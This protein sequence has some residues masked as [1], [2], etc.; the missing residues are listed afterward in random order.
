MLEELEGKGLIIHHWDTDGI[1]STHILLWHLKD[2][3]IDNKT[4]ELGNYYLTE[5]EIKNYSKYDF[6]YCSLSPIR[7]SSCRDNTYHSWRPKWWA[8][9][10]LFIKRRTK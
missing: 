5:E 7:A 8:S 4:P 3:K 6:L 1:C 2:K 10:G 9:I